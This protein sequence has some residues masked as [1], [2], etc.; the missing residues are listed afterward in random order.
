MR[1]S[2]HHPDE[3]QALLLRAAF[4]DLPQAADA[5]AAWRR[6]GRPPD[7]GAERL[8][9]QVYRHL[10]RS[11]DEPSLHALA[12]AYRLTW[13]R[14][15]VRADALGLLL[16]DLDADG[17]PSLVLKGGALAVVAYADWGARPMTDFDV[18]VRRGAA[19]EAIARLGA[20]GFRPSAPLPAGFIDDH[21]GAELQDAAGQ[22]LDLH[23]SL[24]HECCGAGDLDVVWQARVPLALGSTHAATL[25]ATDHLFHVIVHGA[26][27][28]ATQPVGWAADALALLVRPDGAI[29]WDRLIA[30][31]REHEVG[32]PVRSALGWLRSRFPHLVPLA[33]VEAA[34]GI[35]APRWQRVEHAVKVRPRPLVGTLPVLLFDHHRL[36][37]RLGAAPG[38]ARYLQRTFRVPGLSHLPRESA[39]L[40]IGRLRGWLQPASGSRAIGPMQAALVGGTA[41]MLVGEFF[42]LASG[43]GSAAILSRVLGVGGYGLFGLVAAIVYWAE[44]TLPMLYSRA[45]L[46]AKAERD[47]DFDAGVLWLYTGTG[48]LFAC[49]IVLGAPLAGRWLG[50]EGVAGHLMLFAVDVPIAALATGQRVL[51]VARGAYAHVAA[52]GTARAAGRFALIAA[53]L[54]WRPDVTSAIAA[55]IASSVLELG[56]GTALIG[57]GWPRRPRLPRL[58]VR[59]AIVPLAASSL[60]LRLYRRLDLLMVQAIARSDVETGLYG[61]AQNVSLVLTT[62]NNTLSPA[63]LA[64]LSRLDAGA[65]EARRQL[66][67]AALRVLLLPL[68]ALGFCAGCASEI[69]ALVY[70]GAFRPAGLAMALLAVASY[71]E[72]I[73]AVASAPLIAAGRVAPL[74]VATAP[75]VPLAALGHAWA[76]PRLGTGGAAAVTLLLAVACALA[77]IRGVVRLRLVEGAGRGAA[78]AVLVAGLWLAAARALAPAGWAVIPAALAAGIAGAA[79]LVAAGVVPAADLAGVGR[80]GARHGRGPN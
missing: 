75:L 54:A 32:V 14:N 4:A 76:V 23:W 8:L 56:V 66:A 74:V 21:H 53:A 3:V 16:R 1:R 37:R 12:P 67:A 24:A 61:A 72:I 10:N 30:H 55:S 18:L 22:R 51:L 11:V 40:A 77:V 70:G 46:S 68:P 34:A 59:G 17:V 62:I 7:A 47:R 57:A 15:Q 60:S 71:A 38:L 80:A 6:H 79:L 36:R 26:R 20:R 64:S 19:E 25:C 45:V 33:A 48:V 43:V 78:V 42:V 9:P 49:A 41:R 58:D 44:L 27:A 5:W 52:M 73:G 28:G 35:P 69:A 29:D 2:P 13:V 65:D 63:L 50:A 31:A 39:R